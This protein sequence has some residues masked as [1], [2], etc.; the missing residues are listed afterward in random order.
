MFVDS[1]NLLLGI[2]ASPQVFGL[3]HLKAGLAEE[4]SD[5]AMTLWDEGPGVLTKLVLNT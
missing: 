4:T 3:R 1:C 5:H 2:W